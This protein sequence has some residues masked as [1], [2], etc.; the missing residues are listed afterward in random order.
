MKNKS[1]NNF[2]QATFGA[3]CFWCVEAVFEGLEGVIDV[4]VGYAGGKIVHPTYDEVCSGNTD[5]VEVVQIDFNPQIISYEHLLDILWMAHDPTTINQQGADKGSQYRSAIF[6]H[7]DIQHNI[8]EIS[9]KKIEESGVY[10]D[11]IVT[12]ITKM[13]IFY[14]AE[15]YH[16]NYYRVNLDAPYCSM[17]I[18]PK[19]DKLFNNK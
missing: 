8:A 3:G 19:L 5:H 7:N 18:K 4:R 15:D 9:K 17:V 2:D 11:P 10:V 6:Y 13:S 14:L 12:E 1:K 16:Q